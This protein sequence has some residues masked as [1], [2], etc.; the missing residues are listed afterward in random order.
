MAKLCTLYCIEWVGLSSFYKFKPA[1]YRQRDVGEPPPKHTMAHSCSPLSSIFDPAWSLH[2]ITTD[3]V[4]DLHR[5][6][7]ESGALSY[8]HRSTLCCRSF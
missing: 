1:N 4:Q 2:A 5:E 3:V 7:A 8:E 6:G